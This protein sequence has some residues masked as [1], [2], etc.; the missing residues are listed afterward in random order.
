MAISHHLPWQL[1]LTAKVVLSRMPANYRIWKRIGFFN[2]GSMERPEYAYAV[3]RR[4]F[5]VAGFSNRPGFA[6]LELGPGDSI[7]SALIAFA[8][9]AS[10][11]YLVDEGS[12]AIAD[13]SVYRQLVDYL[14]EKGLPVANIPNVRTCEQLLDVCSATYLTQGVLSLREIP[15]ASVD[16]VF[17]HVTL[18]QVK[19]TD[20]VPVLNELRRIQ[21]PDGLGSHRVSIRDYFGGAAND[22]R[23]STPM[24]ESPFMTKS[25][26]YTNRVRYTEMLRLFAQAGFECEVIHTRRWNEL[27]IS[28]TKLA[29]EFANLS[30]DDL[31]IHEWDVLLH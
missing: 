10:Q 28:R 29:R 6:C 7:S 5:D 12:F 17:S 19:R 30:D 20:L 23:F 16:F 18:Q 24:W 15:S 2:Q 9:G 1:N 27:P 31:L 4:H 3:F 25:G 8:L 11:T 21:K 22:L 13:L 14:G 26:F